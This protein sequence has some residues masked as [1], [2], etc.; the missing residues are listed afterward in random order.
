MHVYSK[1][2]VASH[3]DT[4]DT[5][6]NTYIKGHSGFDIHSIRNNIITLIVHFNL[7]LITLTYIAFDGMVRKP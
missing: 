4:V 3:L 6:G 5:K 1:D 7:L 2:T